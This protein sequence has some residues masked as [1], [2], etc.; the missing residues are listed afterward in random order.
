M[1]LH[2]VPSKGGWSVKFAPQDPPALL[3][4]QKIEAI[5]VAQRIA[6]RHEDA[7]ILLYQQDGSPPKTVSL[8][9]RR[10][11]LLSPRR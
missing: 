10:K 11:K 6:A 8:K 5:A 4:E 2:V 9:T 7:T 1:T 3:I